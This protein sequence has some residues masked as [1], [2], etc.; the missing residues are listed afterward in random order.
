MINK[1]QLSK[2]IDEQFLDVKAE[3]ILE[4][5]TEQQNIDIEDI[6]ILNKGNF[7][8]AFRRDIL[9]S[10]ANRD[11][12]TLE[13][14]LTRNGMYDG[15][16]QGVFHEDVKQNSSKSFNQIRSQ[17]KQEERH[18]R[19]LFA[20]LENEFFLQK[21]LVGKNET[22]IVGDISNSNSSFLLSLWGIENKVDKDYVFGL[23]KLLP[24]A[25]KISQNIDLA[26][27]SLQEILKEKTTI[28][29]QYRYKDCNQD[30][31]STETDMTLGQNTALSCKQSSYKMPYYLIVVDIKNNA[32]YPDFMPNGKSYQ[33]ISVF[34]DYF[35]P[36]EIDWSLKITTLNNKN[37]FKLD[38]N[39][40]AVLG[41]TTHL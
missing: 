30:I 41:I 18:A 2:I 27:K 6:T 7:K 26:S 28:I 37:L 9:S 23:T 36:V 8:R 38:K 15:L 1:K 5:L 22:K 25:H 16:P 11:N 24:L 35:F 21:L 39:L 12:N 13:I 19:K 31:S 40:N 20:P 33:L 14:S 34:S 29:Q 32:T 4:H 3:V 17:G 10:Y